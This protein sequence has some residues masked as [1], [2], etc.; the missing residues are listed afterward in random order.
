MNSKVEFFKN[1]ISDANKIGE[2]I[3]PRIAGS[4]KG[5]AKITWSPDKVGNTIIYARTSLSVG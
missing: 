5:T 1:E 4:S 2:C 3:I